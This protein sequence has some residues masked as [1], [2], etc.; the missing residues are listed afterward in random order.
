[1]EIKLIDQMKDDKYILEEKVI[2]M[3]EIAT[4]I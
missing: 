4:K 3:Q 2:K 1:M